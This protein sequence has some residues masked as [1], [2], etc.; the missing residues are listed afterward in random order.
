MLKEDAW[1]MQETVSASNLMVPNLPWKKTAS[2]LG[3][4]SHGNMSL[5]ALSKNRQS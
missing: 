2:I 4:A 5:E 3:G 1:T